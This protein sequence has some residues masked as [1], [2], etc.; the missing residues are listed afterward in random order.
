MQL[1]L[2]INFLDLILAPK[3][4]DQ[5]SITKSYKDSAKMIFAI[6]WN[7]HLTDKIADFLP[8]KTYILPKKVST[9]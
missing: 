2:Q 6:Q 3:S 9:N 4:V 8:F 1:T 5:L 7:F